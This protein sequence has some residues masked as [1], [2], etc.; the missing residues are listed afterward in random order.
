MTQNRSAVATLLAD[1]KQ[2]ITENRYD[3][4]VSRCLSA[5]Q[6]SPDLSD[7]WIELAAIYLRQQRYEQS[8]QAVAQIMTAGESQKVRLQLIAD[9]KS[10]V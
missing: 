5:C 3:E 7:P 8:L 4:A 9:R 10:V 1:A 2:L 6:L